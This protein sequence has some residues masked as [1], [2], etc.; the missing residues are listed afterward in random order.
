MLVLAAS[1]RALA[2]KQ[3]NNQTANSMN[4]TKL[5]LAAA[6][7]SLLAA[8]CCPTAAPTKPAPTPVSTK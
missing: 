1:I 6:A 2:R 3:N 7:A 4:I 8:S 5:A